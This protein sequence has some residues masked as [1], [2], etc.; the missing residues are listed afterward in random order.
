M[1]GPLWPGWLYTTLL[2]LQGD[3]GYEHQNSWLCF[4]SRLNGPIQVIFHFVLKFLKNGKNFLT[5]STPK[6]PP[7]GKKSKISINQSFFQ[8]LY[9]FL[10]EFILHVLS[11]FLRY[12]TFMYLIISNFDLFL[13]EKFYFSPPSFDSQHGQN[14]NS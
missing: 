14:Y 2:F 10:F 12:I 11:F 1:G 6:S 3:R 5:I 8:K 4:C 7:F 13:H 9:F